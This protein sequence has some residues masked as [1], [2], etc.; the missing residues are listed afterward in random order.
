VI[1]V[2]YPFAD[3]LGTMLVF[4]GFVVWLW[5]LIRVFAD[6]FRPRDI[7]GWAKFFWCLL[8]LVVPLVGVLVYLIVQGK[9]IGERDMA[10]AQSGRPN[11][12]HTSGRRPAIVCQ[13]ARSPTRS[14]CSTAGRSARPS[15][16]RSRPR[17]SRSAITFQGPARASFAEHAPEDLR[18]LSGPVRTRAGAGRTKECWCVAWL[19]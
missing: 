4:F 8:V 18:P 10:E 13:R 11:L 5:L 3:V 14:S 12:T 1:A 9:E 15:S 6:V 2:D 17:R 7:G 19:R 16:T